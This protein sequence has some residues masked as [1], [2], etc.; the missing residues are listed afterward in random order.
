MQTPT[1]QMQMIL[2]A[3]QEMGSLPI[4]SLTPEQARLIPLPDKAAV[5]VYGHHIMKKA[6][7][8]FPV[9]VG[10]VEHALI[11]SQ[12]T[13]I[14][15]R[16]YTPMGHSPKG[17]WP[18]LVYFHG[19][20][21]VIA[22]LNVYDSSCRALCEG[23]G[24]V[25]VSVGYRQAPEHPW[26]AATEDAFAAVNWAREQATTLGWNVDLV[27]V[28]GESAGGN[29]AAVVSLMCRD[30]GVAPPVH[31]LLIYPVTDM[32]RGSNSPSALENATAHP[33]NRPMLEWFYGHYAGQSERTHPYL[34]PLYAQTHSNL[35]PATVILAQI[36]P[37]RSDGEAYAMKLMDA[38]VPTV[39]KVYEG[40][41]HEFF[42]LAGLVN[43]ATEAVALA[44]KELRR[45]FASPAHAAVT[46]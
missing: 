2:D 42:G 36:D 10:K 16:I 9:N 23:A 35:P 40:V 17:G 5:Y 41:T 37:L 32:I 19:G 27:A 21:W 28:G 3:H 24:C 38:G 25:V 33:L 43:E 13:E 31:Q 1:S 18:V 8:P 46:V 6:L 15:A 12:D 44:S 4:E 29:L 20:G 30:Q 45:A 11:P 26:P 22:D 14:V 7:T 34:S 39:L